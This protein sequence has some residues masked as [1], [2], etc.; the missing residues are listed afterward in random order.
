MD[1][2]VAF[3][4]KNPS[5]P[6]NTLIEAAEAGQIGLTPLLYRRFAWSPRM[7]RSALPTVVLIGDDRG[8]SRNPFKS[9]S[10]DTM[11]QLWNLRDD[12]RR[13]ASAQELARTPG[14]DAAQNAWDV[15]RQL[16]TQGAMHVGANI[17]APGIGSL[18][19]RGVQSATQ[20]IFTARRARLATA[21]G[22]ELL[23]PKTP[24]RNPLERP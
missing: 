22:M 6:L 9:I 5:Q 3:S 12:L 18:A 19:L 20:P 13:S 16:G 21:R 4:R 24:L 14:G 2:A 15:A 17:L 11:Q 23:H 1:R 10:D 8:D 7:I